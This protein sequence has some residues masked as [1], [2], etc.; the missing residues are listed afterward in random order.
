MQYELLIDPRGIGQPHSMVLVALHSPRM[1]AAAALRGAI[2]DTAWLDRTESQFLFG[3]G[4]GGTWLLAYLPVGAVSDLL[5]SA[6]LC[7][8][9]LTL[10]RLVDAMAAIEREAARLRRPGGSGDRMPQVWADGAVHMV[11]SPDAVEELVGDWCGFITE[12]LVCR[13]RANQVMVNCYPVPDELIREWAEL[14][15]QN[16]EPEPVAV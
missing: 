14:A 9:P 7:G 5:L 10:E 8:V 16:V 12:Q 11:L 1:G 2:A 4:R 6:D 15:A 3:T 13:V